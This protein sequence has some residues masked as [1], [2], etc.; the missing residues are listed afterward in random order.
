MST[1]MAVLLNGIAQIE[2][3]RTKPLPDHQGAYL[4]RMD[5]RMDEEGIEIDGQVVCRPDAGQKAQ[6]VA[7]NLAHAIKTD[8]EGMAAALATW[9]AVRLPDLRQVKMREDDRGF[10]IEL[11]FDED[12]IKQH[13][14][15]LTPRRRS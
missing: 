6:F 11:S 4:D 8:D 12:Y 9:L 3:D 1:M 7:G 15:Q 2:Y 5:R 10:A 13:P 14:V